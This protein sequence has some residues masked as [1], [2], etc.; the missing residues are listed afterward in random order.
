MN[1]LKPPKKYFEGL[2]NKK[3]ECIKEDEKIENC[4]FENEKY[5]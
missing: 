4:Q 3:L 1:V 5:S 2:E